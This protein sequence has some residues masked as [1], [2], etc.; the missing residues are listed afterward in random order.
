MLVNIYTI[1]FQLINIAVLFYFLKRLLYKPVGNFLE[2]RR[3]EIKQQFAEAENK[4]QEAQKLYAEYNKRLEHS[5]EEIE[6]IIGQAK[7]EAELLRRELLEKARQEASSLLENARRD[8]ERQ[9]ARALS[10]VTEKVAD[11]SVEISSKI[12]EERLSPE[13][14]HRLIQKAMER[15]DERRWVQ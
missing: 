9:K 10:E 15:M 8:I 6:G 2:R 13:D 7:K 5:R 4:R 11:L 12:L 3:E 1:V 14:H